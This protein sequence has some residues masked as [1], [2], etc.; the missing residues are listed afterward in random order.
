MSST[1]AVTEGRYVRSLSFGVGTLVGG[2]QVD[3]FVVPV[4]TT[5]LVKSVFLYNPAG[6]DATAY[7]SVR[8]AGL[9]TVLRPV[10]PAGSGLEVVMWLALMP[11]Q[12]FVL[13]SGVSFALNFAV[14]GAL[15]PGVVDAAFAATLPR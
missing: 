2:G 4:E 13:T 10:V 6:S 8:G 5:A 7:V 14:S 15:L 12:A 3:L 1:R 11:G 9:T